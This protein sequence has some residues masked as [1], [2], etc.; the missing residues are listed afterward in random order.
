MSR[1]AHNLGRSISFQTYH[2]RQQHAGCTVEEPASN[3][4]QPK[5]SEAAP[6]MLQM[7]DAVPVNVTVPEPTVHVLVPEHLPVSGAVP[8]LRV[9][10]L[11]PEHVPEAVPV[12]LSVPQAVPVKR[13]SP[14][15][16]KVCF[17]PNVQ[18]V[19]LRI[20]KKMQCT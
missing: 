18:K 20:H 8:E 2:Q 17:S 13:S 9:H 7:S 1:L 4:S 19:K 14:S 5:R 3:M 6:M 11:V 16:P 12:H 15:I 10:V